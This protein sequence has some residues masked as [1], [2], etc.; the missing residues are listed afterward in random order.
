MSHA[1]E[2][3]AATAP[4]LRMPP[5]MLSDICPWFLRVEAQFR[6]HGVTSSTRKAD[7][8]IAALPAE[9]FALLAPWIFSKG[10]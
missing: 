8:V 6:I 2:T 1:E 10:T 3:A 7:H 5:F 9:T 4:A